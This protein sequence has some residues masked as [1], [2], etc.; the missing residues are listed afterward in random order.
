VAAYYAWI[1]NA[2]GIPEPST[3]TLL[4]AS[5]LGLGLTRRRRIA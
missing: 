5:A 4:M 1:K 2:A 3:I